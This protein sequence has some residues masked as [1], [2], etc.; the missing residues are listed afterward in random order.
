MAAN[1]EEVIHGGDEGDLEGQIVDDLEAGDLLGIAGGELLDAGNRIQVIADLR[2]ALHVGI[3]QT[4]PAALE[5]LGVHG[6]AVVELHALLE[7]E[8]VHQTVLRDGRELVSAHGSSCV[9][10]P[11]PGD[12]TVEHRAD[13][14]GALVL[15]RV[16]RVDERGLAQVEVH[17]LATLGTATVAALAAATGQCCQGARGECAANEGATTHNG[18]FEVDLSH[19]IL[20]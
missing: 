2:G 10:V 14:G 18:L 6:V 11:I 9:L 19:A 1:S 4:G 7:L 13:H 17:D 5:G 12:Q 3:Y 15:L 16:V 20:L 8:G